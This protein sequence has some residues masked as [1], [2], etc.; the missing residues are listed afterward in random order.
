MANFDHSSEKERTVD[1]K[2]ISGGMKKSSNE[3]DVANF[4]HSSEKERTV[5]AKHISGG[6]K[7]RKEHTAHPLNLSF[8]QSTYRIALSDVSEK[9][10]ARVYKAKLLYHRTLH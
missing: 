1:T 8:L 3:K 4:D 10:V 6:M 5:D 9:E 2:H 7:K